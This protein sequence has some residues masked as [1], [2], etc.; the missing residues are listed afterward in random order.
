[1]GANLKTEPGFG[2]ACLHIPNG[3]GVKYDGPLTCSFCAETYPLFLVDR[4]GLVAEHCRE[5]RLGGGGSARGTNDFASAERKAG[6]NQTAGKTSESPQG[7]T[8]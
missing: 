3:I 8:E 2:V 6:V 7:A 1:M 5:K 4:L